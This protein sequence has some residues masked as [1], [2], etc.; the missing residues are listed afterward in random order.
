[1][2][3]EK[4]NPSS[5]VAASSIEAPKRIEVDASGRRLDEAQDRKKPLLNFLLVGAGSIFT[6]MII[7]GFLLG[8][9]LDSLLNTKPIFIL[10]CGVLGFV[11]G[12]MKI[13]QMLSKMDLLDTQKKALHLDEEAHQKLDALS[14][15]M[16]KRKP[17]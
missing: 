2:K 6:S 17:K 1:M 16:L 12:V 15:K 13:H 10:T 7:A 4:E 11:G 14:K 3:Q 9:M 5:S 8:Y